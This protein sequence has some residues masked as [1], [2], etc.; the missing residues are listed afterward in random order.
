MIV[1]DPYLD[2]GT[3]TRLPGHLDKTVKKMKFGDAIKDADTIIFSTAHKDYREL[4][5]KKFINNIKKDVKIIDLWNMYEGK[6]DD[7]SQIG[8][9]GLGRGDLR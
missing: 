4:N 3:Y 6:L 2:K 1:S 7:Q 5:I 8:Y 9:V